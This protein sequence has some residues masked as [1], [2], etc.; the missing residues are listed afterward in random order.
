M[1]HPIRSPGFN[2]LTLG[3]DASAQDL[4]VRAEAANREELSVSDSYPTGDNR[5]SVPDPKSVTYIDYDNPFALFKQSIEASSHIVR[6]SKN[7]WVDCGEGIY[8]LECLGKGHLR[9][10][11]V[12]DG[13]RNWRQALSARL[14][15]SFIDGENHFRAHYTPTIHP[16]TASALNISKFVRN[17]KILDASS[18]ADAVRGCDTYVSG[19]VL[20]GRLS[21]AQV[22][23]LS[24]WSWHP[25]LISLK[26]V[27]HGEV[28]ARTSISCPEKLCRQEVG[29]C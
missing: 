4:E 29:I 23:S 11:P 22:F 19:N 28:A 26:V 8:V 9:I 5:L 1:V 24:F 18:L 21:L 13:E 20:R 2:T 12:S 10:E 14:T 25:C 3:L 27:A 15:S 6:L 17:R 7:A 16:E